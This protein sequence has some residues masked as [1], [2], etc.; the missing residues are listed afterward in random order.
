[1]AFA[2]ACERPADAVCSPRAARVGASDSPSSSVARFVDAARLRRDADIAAVWSDGRKLQHPLFTARALPNGM[3][4]MRLAVSA[5]R[6]LGRAVARNR[7]RRRLRDAFRTVI[8]DLESRPG[9]DL[10]VV[11]RRPVASAPYP[12]LRAAAAKALGSLPPRA[13]G[14]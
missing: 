9:C 14:G 8:R 3:T 4:A 11:A 5:P 10:V 12:E 6:S 1:M 13:E 2:R 7:A